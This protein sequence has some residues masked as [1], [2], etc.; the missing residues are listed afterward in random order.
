MYIFI[1]DQKFIAQK[2]DFYHRKF[3][4]KYQAIFQNLTGYWCCYCFL[5]KRLFINVFS[6][7]FFSEF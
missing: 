7:N 6:G 4:I 5:C 2:M 3:A 1:Y